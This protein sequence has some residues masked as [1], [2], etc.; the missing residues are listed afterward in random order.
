VQ[1]IGRYN[2]FKKY[3]NILIRIN[4]DIPI[5]WPNITETLLKSLRAKKDIKINISSKFVAIKAITATEQVKI[6]SIL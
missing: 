5:Y 3:A 4:A 2:K 1:V 6:I